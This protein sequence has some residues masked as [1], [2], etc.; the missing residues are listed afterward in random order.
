DSDSDSDNDNDNTVRVWD[1]A[2]GE[3]VVEVI[4]DSAER[5]SVVQ[6]IVFNPDGSQ[7]AFVTMDRVRGMVHIWTLAP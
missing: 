4:D 7:L 2:S 5:A 6:D 1:V 3:L